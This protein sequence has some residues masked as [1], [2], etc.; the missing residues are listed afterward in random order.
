MRE[1]GLQQTRQ[2][3]LLTPACVCRCALRLDRSAKARSQWGHWNGRSPVCVRKWPCSS[4]GREK[5]LPQ[6]GQR[7]GRVCVRTCILSAPIVLYTYTA[8]QSV[9]SGHYKHLFGPIGTRDAEYCDWWSRTFVSLFATR[10]RCANTAERIEVLLGMESL[11]DQGNIVL[12][13]S[14]RFDAAFAKLY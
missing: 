8:N 3:Y 10:L 11:G 14:H 1:N 12:D 4:H 6:R 5:A 13:G 2:R 9:S 7:H